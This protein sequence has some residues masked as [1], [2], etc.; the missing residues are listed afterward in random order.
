VHAIPAGLDPGFRVVT[1]M[2]ARLTHTT[3]TEM[4]LAQTRRA[5][6]HVHATPATLAAV[7]LA[8]H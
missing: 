2:S 8:A 7:F 5:R 6:S 3:V 1:T 4:R